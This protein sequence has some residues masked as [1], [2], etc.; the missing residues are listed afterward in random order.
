VSWEKP[1]AA[2]PHKPAVKAARSH[3]TISKI[4]SLEEAF[5]EALF[6]SEQVRYKEYGVDF[7]DTLPKVVSIYRP[8]LPRITN[9]VSD[10]AGDQ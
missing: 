5:Q 2:A 9:P 7:G 1:G 8:N 4:A 3:A 10:L 6:E